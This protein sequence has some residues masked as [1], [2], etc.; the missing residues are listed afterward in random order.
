MTTVKFLV[1]GQQGVNQKSAAL[2]T[3]LSLAL[4][5]SSA[6]LS[7][8]LFQDTLP[9]SLVLVNTENQTILD[10]LAA[11]YNNA[12]INNIT[13]LSLLCRFIFVRISGSC[14]GLNTLSS[15][16]FVPSA[17]SHEI[18]HC[19]NN[20][21]Q[22]LQAIVSVHLCVVIYLACGHLTK[23][24]SSAPIRLSPP[25]SVFWTPADPRRTS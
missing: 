25:V 7:L 2:Q 5:G 18:Q 6:S 4:D 21:R 14:V 24:A 10:A 22:L 1:P 9:F 11:Q 19:C 15:L 17:P 16:Y 20:L 12:S 13:G 23:A 3:N 8:S